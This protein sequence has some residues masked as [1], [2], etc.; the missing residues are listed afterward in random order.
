MGIC[1]GEFNHKYYVAFLYFFLI[2][3]IIMLL[4][5]NSAIG[6]EVSIDEFGLETIS[7]KYWLYALSIIALYFFTFIAI[8]LTYYHTKYMLNNQTTWERVRRDSISYLKSVRP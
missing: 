3:E 5:F 4:T 8:Y 1:I 7:F 2:N 6:G